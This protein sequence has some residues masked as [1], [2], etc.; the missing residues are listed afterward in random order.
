MSK[1]K[2][3]AFPFAG[4]SSLGYLKWKKYLS[5]SIELMPVELAGRGS[6]MKNP[7]YKNFQEAVDDLYGQIQNDIQDE[8][9]AFFG[10]SMG[11]VLAYELVHKIK[12]LGQREPTVIFM[13]GRRPPHINRREIFDS[14][15][16]EEQLKENLLEL[17]GA[18]KELFEDTQLA[19]TFIPILR[20][21][22]ELMETYVYEANREPLTAAI[23]VMTGIGDA[24][25]NR[26]DLKEW[27]N[28][29]TNECTIAKF[30]GGHF[31]INDSFG[32]MIQQINRVLNSIQTA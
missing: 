23:H 16:P 31:Y 18:T 3:F 28:H 1:L 19:Q 4:S 27:R 5:E 8:P 29:T 14:S 26:T 12:Q 9:Y 2:L 15:F 32:I 10:H 24:D 6:R 21:D 17:G 20:A 11:S 30:K 25:V 7:F 13:S 22:F